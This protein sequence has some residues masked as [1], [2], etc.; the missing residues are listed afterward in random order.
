MQEK[1]FLIKKKRV[2]LRCYKE[3]LKNLHFKRLDCLK[4]TV[5][6]FSCLSGWGAACQRDKPLHVPLLCHLHH[7]WIVLYLEF[8][9]RCHHRQLQSAE[10]NDRCLRFTTFP[11][12]FSL[13]LMCLNENNSI[14]LFSVLKVARIYSWPKSRKS[15]TTRWRNLDPKSHRSQFQDQW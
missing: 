13:H 3:P 11:K 5:L 6:C 9:H 2:H 10:T 14:W 15:T 7:L 1:S 12:A 8:V 4:K